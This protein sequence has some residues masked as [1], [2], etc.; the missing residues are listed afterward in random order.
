MCKDAGRWF[1]CNIANGR[2]V[3]IHLAE[4]MIEMTQ[5]DRDELAAAYISNFRDGT[6]S[7]TRFV[8]ALAALSMNATDI[9]ALVNEHKEANRAALEKGLGEVS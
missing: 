4:P 1:C 7:R 5:A 2:A 6:F 3:E 9:D 8:A